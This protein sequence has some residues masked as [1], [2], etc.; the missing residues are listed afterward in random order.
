MMSKI[1]HSLKRKFKRIE[2]SMREEEDATGGGPSKQSRGA[3]ETSG[4]IFDKRQHFA[5]QRLPS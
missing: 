1:S 2:N 5:N 3:P 4:P